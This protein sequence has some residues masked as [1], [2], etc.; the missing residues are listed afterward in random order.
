MTPIE[1]EHKITIYMLDIDD[2]V[3]KQNTLGLLAMNDKQFWA[4]IEATLADGI[5][6]STNELETYLNHDDYR[7]FIEFTIN[8][9]RDLFCDLVMDTH[10]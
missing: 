6:L 8:F 7:G 5:G 10:D 3:D 1:L 9:I 4:H 2:V